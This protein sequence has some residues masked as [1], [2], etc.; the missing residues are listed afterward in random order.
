MAYLVKERTSAKYTITLKD[1]AGVAIPKADVSSFKVTL[2]CLDDDAQTILNSRNASE[3]ATAFS[4]NITMGATDG[5][6]T[7]NMQP[8]DNAI[9]AGA[10]NKGIGYERHRLV[11]DVT[12]SNG[13]R[14]VYEDE[15]IVQN[16]SVTS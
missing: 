10:P 7:F 5:L 8:A 13:T 9:V 1:Q 2:L 6:V 16:Q 15:I 12:L 11:F 3:Q 4:G 14:L